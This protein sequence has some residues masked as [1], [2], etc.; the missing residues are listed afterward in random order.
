MARVSVREMI[1]KRVQTD[2]LTLSTVSGDI[3][4]EDTQRTFDLLWYC[5]Q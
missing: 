3:Q 4:T 5:P 1:G 2:I